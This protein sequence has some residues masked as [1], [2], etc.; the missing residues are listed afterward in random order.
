MM[1][2]NAKKRLL[3]EREVRVLHI[4]G[5]ALVGGV[6]SFLITLARNKNI[7]PNAKHEFAFTTTGPT[8]DRIRLAEAR[9]HYLGAATYKQPGALHLAR[10][11]LAEIC[12]EY[13]YDIAVIHQY[14]YLV[15][16]FT[17][18]L[19]TRGIKKVRYFHN[20]I[21]PNYWVERLV[22]L[23]SARFLDL[24]VFDSYFLRN[25][26]PGISGT[27]V[28]YPTDQQ[29]E[30]TREQRNQIRQRFATP[31]DEPLVVQACRM[32]ER[33]GH[34]LLLRALVGLKSLPWTC[35]IVGGPQTDDQ[36]TYFNGITSL[37][38]RLG[39]ADRVRF[40]GMRNDVP[41]L[42]AAADIFCHPNTYPPEPFGI[43]FV[44]AL[45]AG[46]PVVTTAIGGAIEIVS[47]QCGL[48]VPPDNGEAL[49]QALGRLLTESSLRQQMSLAARERGKKFA[50]SVQIPILNATLRS[51]LVGA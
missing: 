42:L 39:I 20:T 3:L 37:A 9:V 17:D 26:F 27:V 41:E 5:D 36:T 32:V 29:I 14:A 15:A 33:K 45:Q 38:A 8:L 13:K 48:L 50:A 21:D 31:P 4:S 19:S 12:D 43:A 44:E 7:D 40:L 1:F 2:D 23:V 49:S 46:L 25:C 18:I 6:E 47:E 30:L 16:A 51:T 11:R 24:T 28:Y 34:A 10:R 22:R 35:W